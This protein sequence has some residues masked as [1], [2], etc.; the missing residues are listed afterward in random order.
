LNN[1]LKIY[2]KG[3][4]QVPSFLE[5]SNRCQYSAV[6]CLSDIKQSSKQS[7]TGES[8]HSRLAILFK[9]GIC[10]AGPFIGNDHFVFQAISRIPFCF[11]EP[12][13]F[14]H[15]LSL[16]AFLF[17]NQLG[18]KEMTPLSWGGNRV[19]PYNEQVFEMLRGTK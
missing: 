7:T 13:T 18:L 10:R 1:G 2:C 19:F 4:D 3:G 6:I 8:L 5:W 11:I 9:I 16:P 14:D 15:D 12:I 17:S